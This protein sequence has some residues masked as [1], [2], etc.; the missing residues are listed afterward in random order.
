[1]DRSLD[2]P[3]SLFLIIFISSLSCLAY[4]IAL[5]RIFSITLWYHFAFMVISIAMLGIGAS[6]TMLAVAPRLK[7]LRRVPSTACC[8][9]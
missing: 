2:K 4:E 3:R 5:V 8:W 7:D 6:G 1:M 9:Q